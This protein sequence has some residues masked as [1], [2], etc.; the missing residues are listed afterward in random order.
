MENKKGNGNG[1]FFC[2]IFEINMVDEDRNDILHSSASQ[3]ANKGNEAWQTRD[4]ESNRDKKE[5]N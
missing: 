4:Q 1:M 3:S 5:S 2:R